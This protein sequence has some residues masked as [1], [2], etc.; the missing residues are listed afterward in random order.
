VTLPRWTRQPALVPVWIAASAL[1][2]VYAVTLS[3]LCWG[4]AFFTLLNWAVTKDLAGR[5]PAR[6]GIDW[7]RRTGVISYSIYLTHWPAVWLAFIALRVVFGR[8]ALTPNIPEY[9]AQLAFL[10][11]AGYGGGWAYFQ[12]IERRFLNRPKEAIDAASV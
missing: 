8:G 9:F 5:W 12:L 11:A 6:R 3:P 4:M 7:L 2:D 1:A 10:V